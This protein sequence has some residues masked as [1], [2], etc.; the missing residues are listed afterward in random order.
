MCLCPPNILLQQRLEL[1]YMTGAQNELVKCMEGKGPE[2]WASRT[3]ESV[4]TS[5][6]QFSQ[7]GGLQNGIALGLA[8]SFGSCCLWFSEK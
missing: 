1:T 8:L 2:H 7:A 3:G 5:T 4:R 6:Y